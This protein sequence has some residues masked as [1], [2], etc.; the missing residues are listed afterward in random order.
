MSDAQIWM[1]NAH[2]HASMEKGSSHSQSKLVTGCLK[3]YLLPLP[4][5]DQQH[6]QVSS[7]NGTRV[8]YQ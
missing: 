3:S 4:T 5:V 1:V 7:F 6:P 2:L 8:P